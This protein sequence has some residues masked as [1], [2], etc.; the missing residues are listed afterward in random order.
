MLLVHRLLPPVSSEMDANRM[1]NKIG[2]QA[3]TWVVM[4]QSNP[5]LLLAS[6]LSLLGRSLIKAEVLPEGLQM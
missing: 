2:V 6:A 5:S 4:K 3:A 1:L